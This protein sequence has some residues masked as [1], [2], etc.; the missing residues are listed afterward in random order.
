LLARARIEVRP[1]AALVFVL[2]ANSSS[3]LILV[4][5]LDMRSLPASG[6]GV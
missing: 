2:R 4:R 6:Y 3:H 1:S 5:A